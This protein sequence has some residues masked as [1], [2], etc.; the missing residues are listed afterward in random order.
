MIA[1]TIESYLDTD[2][3]AELLLRAGLNSDSAPAKARQFVRAANALLTDGVDPGAE[4]IGLFVP[5]RIE[6]L[7]K[8]TDYCGGHSLIAAAERGI[9][10][11]A[12]PRA[13]ALVRAIVPDLEDQR[14]FILAAD[15]EPTPGGWSNYPMTVAKRVA[16]NFPGALRGMSVAYCGDLP[17]DSG[18]SSSSAV[19][20]GMF[21]VISEINKLESRI[22]YRNNI[23]DRR[24]LAAYLGSIENGSD[25]GSLPGTRGVGT[26]G[27]SEDHT[28]ILNALAGWVGRYSY[29]PVTMHENLHLDD[30]YVFAIACSGVSA[31]KT[32]SAREKYN[33]MSRRAR[34][35]LELWREQTGRDDPH[36]ASAIASSPEAPQQFSDMLS[37]GA[38]DLTGEELTTRLDQFRAENF[39]IIPAACKA[40]A[41]GDMEEFG[42][43]IDRSQDLADTQLGSQVPQTVFLAH[44]ARELG[45]TAASSFGA[46]FGG[47]V[48]ALVLRDQAETFGERWSQ[49]YA[50]AFGA[51]SQLATFFSTD[52]GPAAFFVDQA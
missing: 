32:G 28:A 24:T 45:A 36:L 14:Q 6:V 12:A 29:F 31:P 48:W 7:G 25:F 39:E 30:K 34:V 17:A 51:E 10:F 44:A 33:R 15:I 21:L 4:A 22:E 38:D 5:G 43:Q 41:C 3:L 37:G 47:A 8:H 40:L 50:E 35:A 13:D 11:L 19:L 27:G 42:L 26:A 46:G 1:G 18:M 9:C 52:P 2:Y 20:T 49:R 23:F 16:R